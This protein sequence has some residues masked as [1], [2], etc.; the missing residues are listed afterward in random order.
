MTGPM[1]AAAPASRCSS[2]S[3]IVPRS[4]SS[5][6]SLKWAR[7]ARVNDPAG[8]DL[9]E[10][11]DRNAGALLKG[12]DIAESDTIEIFVEVAEATSDGKI[13]PGRFRLEDL[14]TRLGEIGGGIVK[15]S[16]LLKHE[17]SE[18]MKRSGRDAT[19]ARLDSVEFAFKLALKAEVGL[20]VTRGSG[21]ASFEVRM[22]WQGRRDLETD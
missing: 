1:S 21:E 20:L 2:V 4:S 17:I 11:S 12:S 7:I 8:H 9:E 18:T 19:S 3:L 5:R 6:R 16:D 13:S 14:P 22:T 15:I 10:S